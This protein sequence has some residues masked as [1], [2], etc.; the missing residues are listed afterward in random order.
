MK[1]GASCLWEDKRREDTPEV[2]RLFSQKNLPS[3]FGPENFI[4]QIRERY[5]LRKNSYEVPESRQLAPEA[6]AIIRAV[7]DHYNV[8]LDDLLIP[9]RSHFNQ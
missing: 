5:Y 6:D 9:R 8:G 4:T 1:Q 3:L 7:C 2:T